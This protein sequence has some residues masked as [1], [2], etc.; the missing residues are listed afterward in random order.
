[1]HRFQPH[2]L[3]SLIATLLI[4]TWSLCAAAQTTEGPR[5]FKGSNSTQ[6]VSVQQAG[7]GFAF[8]AST[9]STAATGAV[10]G[11]ATGTSGFTNGVWGRTFSTAGVG[12]RGEA[13]AAS[14]AASGGAFFTLSST[15]VG[16]LGS[17]C[18]ANS[19]A[20]CNGIGVRGI[21]NGLN[22]G[23]NSTAALFEIRGS[24][25]GTNL[26]VGKFDGGNVFR[27]DGSGN[28]FANGCYCVGGADFAESVAVAGK[29]SMYEPGDVLVIDPSSN[30]KVALSQQAYSTLVAGIYSTKP[31]VLASP[32]AVAA[33]DLTR[34][35]DVPLAV[36]GIV[37]TKVTA[38]NGPIHRGDLLVTSNQAGYAM[39]GTD[40][41]RMTGAIVG[42][43]LEPLAKGNGV[44]Q[45]LITLQ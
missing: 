2:A 29:K 30:R 23:P 6:V 8:K 41:G 24:D 4:G 39:K 26:V 18:N 42:K 16:V 37:P 25:G 5:I 33:S 38:A 15:G 35:E 44:I 45:V 3:T 14:G 11:A 43:A 36:I 32:H 13:M 21:V 27:V 34:S 22:Q 31:G 12:V 40:R 28:V 10:F 1:M 20:T 9:P 7:S 19:T 17:A